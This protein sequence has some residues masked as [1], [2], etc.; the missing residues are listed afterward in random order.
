MEGGGVLGERGESGRRA[1]G[2]AAAAGRGESGECGR[3][4]SGEGWPFP[5]RDP[6]TRG[7]RE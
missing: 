5:K 1:S 2:A 6:G 3:R 4:A 7:V